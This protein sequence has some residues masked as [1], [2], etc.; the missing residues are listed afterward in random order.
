MAT[1]VEMTLWTT[2]V[3][4][5]GDLAF[6]PSPVGNL[7]FGESIKGFFWGGRPLKQI[8][9]NRGLNQQKQGYSGDII[10]SGGY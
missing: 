1:I 6:C 2:W 4:L 9:D 7:P 10:G 5:V 8:Q 3:C